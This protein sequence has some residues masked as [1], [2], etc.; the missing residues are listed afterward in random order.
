MTRLRPA[1]PQE[2]EALTDLAMR[3]KAYWG[4]DDDFMARCP[5]ALT[6]R[7]EDVLPR[8]ATVADVDGRI[9]GFVTLDGSP[10]E[11]EVDMLFV[12]PW[13]IGTGVGRLL[14]EHAVRTARANGFTS[15]LIEADPQA[16]SFYARMGAVR[17]GERV[18]PATGRPLPLLRASL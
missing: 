8:H 15:L 2:A 11:G 7:P 1:L 5:P 16:E 18:S 9:A 13:A 6:L 3:S 12:E 10:P 17:I 4:Y 14:Y